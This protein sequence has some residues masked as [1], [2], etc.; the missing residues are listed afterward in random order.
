L[1]TAATFTALAL[2]T[3]LTLAQSGRSAPPATPLPAVADTG[4]PAMTLA[5]AGRSAPV[6]P[7][8][9]V[10]YLVDLSSGQVLFERDATRRFVPASVTKVM[11][12]YSAFK[13]LGSGKLKADQVITVPKE[14][15]DVW[16]GE[17]SSM[18]LKEGDR[19]TISQLLMGTTTV[20]G[21]DAAVMLAITAAG[22]LP[23]WLEVMNANAAELGMRDTHYGSPNGYPDE[24]RTYSSGRDLARLAEAMVTRYPQLYRQYIG[25]HG[26]TWHNI[27]QANHDPITGR[28]DGADGI[29]TGYTRQ[30]GYT[31][32]GSAE[33]DG[34]RLVMVLGA[35]PNIPLRNQVARDLMEWG[36]AAFDSRQLLP[37]GAQVG[38]AQVQGGAADSVPLKTVRPVL[39]SMVRGTD[40]P[41]SMAVRYR[42]PLEAPVKAGQTVAFLRVSAP[43]QQPHDVPLVAAQDVPAAGL[44]R[45]LRNGL[46][47]FVS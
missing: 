18:F 38:L 14:V 33:R 13:L 2:A 3:G 46:T 42:G 24:G 19:V 27:T 44:W 26:F 35:V 43:G 34:R 29:K 23:G 11:T 25:N 47:G 1:K 28:V 21:N 41:M 31:F 16:S 8:V 39:A 30:A 4:T 36:F 22:S 20:S 15:A 45:R 10:A 37:G 7:E 32:L 12:A 5:P 9:P 6:P 17:G 40:A